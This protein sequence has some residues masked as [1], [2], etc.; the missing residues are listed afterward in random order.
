MSLNPES[1]EWLVFCNSALFKAIEEFAKNRSPIIQDLHFPFI[2]GLALCT[3]KYRQ[4]RN[5][6]KAMVDVCQHIHDVET[7]VG[8]LCSPFQTVTASG[9]QQHVEALHE[10][11]TKH[12][13]PPP[14]PLNKDL[15]LFFVENHCEK[16]N[17]THVFTA[18]N[19]VQNSCHIRMWREWWIFNTDPV[20]LANMS[21]LVV[22]LKYTQHCS[23]ECLIVRT[24]GLRY[25][26]CKYDPHV[27]TL[28]CGKKPTFSIVPK[29]N[30]F[31]VMCRNSFVSHRTFEAQFSVISSSFFRCHYQPDLAFQ[32]DTFG[33][34]M[35]KHILFVSFERMVKVFLIRTKKYFK[36]R[37]VGDWSQ[38]ER[39]WGFDGPG[40]LC[41]HILMHSWKQVSVTTF[42]SL[43]HI[44]H[45]NLNTTHDLNFSYHSS[46]EVDRNISLSQSKTHV[47]T[48]KQIQNHC[49]QNKVLHCVVQITAPPSPKKTNLSSNCK[50]HSSIEC[51][52]ENNKW[53]VNTSLQLLVFDGPSSD[54][55][56]YGGFLLYRSVH[57]Y[58]NEDLLKKRNAQSTE[59]ADRAATLFKPHVPSHKE[60][61]FLVCDNR[62]SSANSDLPKPVTMV[63]HGNSVVIILYH[64][65][66]YVKNFELV[67]QVKA[68]H[69]QG[70]SLSLKPDYWPVIDFFA[71]TKLHPLNH[72]IF[73]DFNDVFIQFDQIP[74]NRCI[75]LDI[76]F[77][78]ESAKCSSTFRN[79]FLFLK[80]RRATIRH[81]SVQFY[82]AK[83]DMQYTIP[84]DQ[85]SIVTCS[86]NIYGSLG[87]F[88]EFAFPE[89][90]TKLKI[91]KI[92]E[93]QVKVSH[94][95]KQ[96]ARCKR[97]KYLEELEPDLAL[98]PSRNAR[99]SKRG[100]RT[101]FE[102]YTIRQYNSSIWG[103]FLF[104]SGSS[105]C[106]FKL[107]VAEEHMRIYISVF[108]ARLFGDGF[109]KYDTC[110]R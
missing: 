86:E 89:K 97:R 12:H 31:V 54:S 80:K 99:W 28:L 58:F 57:K 90:A 40:P 20:F 36:L 45:G 21:F 44:L 91:I 106:N 88:V 95:S 87:D 103:E 14:T 17:M 56:L 37:F 81:V 4:M 66:A 39:V 2:G 68:S 93:E 9:L 74:D 105:H 51:F 43:V 62:S 29:N 109:S 82:L 64:Y 53:F 72:A 94:T 85:P 50:Q 34:L 10:Y 47:I 67:L 3:R 110:K 23:V 16:E 49:G 26:E 100:Q 92:F 65:E 108:L 107:L 75:V 70:V 25:L 60:N 41:P 13:I 32:E 48:T 30:R 24:A 5:V 79:N 33:F 83:G 96:A 98:M 61:E 69:C 18:C 76:S 46:F 55:C 38:F 27:L 101:A 71:G 63:S 73:K 52:L 15:H 84:N 104:N 59:E 19:Y 102:S 78:K 11:H 42:Q 22:H 7:V 8:R 6:L 35:M 1:K 77:D